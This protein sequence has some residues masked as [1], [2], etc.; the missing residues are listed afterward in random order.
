MI[1]YLIK[2]LFNFFR[3]QIYSYLYT[4]NNSLNSKNCIEILILLIV[5]PKNSIYFITL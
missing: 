3:I 5:Y 2:P 1:I 4:I